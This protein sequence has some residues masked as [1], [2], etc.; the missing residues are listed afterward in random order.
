SGVFAQ[1]DAVI[2]VRGGLA[3]L[4]KRDG[5]D[6]AQVHAAMFIP[7]LILDNPCAASALAETNT[8]T[9]DVIV[10]FDVIRL[11]LGQMELG[12]S[13]NCQFDRWYLPLSGKIMGRFPTAFP[14][15]PWP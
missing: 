11:A 2:E 10:P 6:S 8:E 7:D 15:L 4:A 5:R 12:Y 14:V 9:G 13:K 1:L 3:R